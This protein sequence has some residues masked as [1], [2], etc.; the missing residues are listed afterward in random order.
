MAGAF[1]CRF[2]IL[3]IAAPNQPFR[4]EDRY[5]VLKGKRAFNK[6]AKTLFS[7][8]DLTSYL[9]CHPAG[10]GAFP[11]RVMDT[12]NLLPLMYKPPLAVLG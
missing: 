2:L 5:A 11:M 10:N 3:L 9:V 8:F 6:L 1:Y 7:E 4:L 12:Q